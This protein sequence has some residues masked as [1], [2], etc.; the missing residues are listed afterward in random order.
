MEQVLLEPALEGDGLA[1]L[2]FEVGDVILVETPDLIV[3]VQLAGEFIA[4]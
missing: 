4:L 3:V 1:I 2:D